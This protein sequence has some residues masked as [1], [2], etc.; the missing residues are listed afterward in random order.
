MYI[1]REAEIASLKRDIAAERKEIEGM[2]AAIAK[3]DAEI[4]ETKAKIAA[5]RKEIERLE[6]EKAKAMG[7]PEVEPKAQQSA[8]LDEANERRSFEETS[9]LE[10]VPGLAED[11]KDGMATPLEDC[12]GQQ[13]LEW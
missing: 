3:A 9:Y 2:K 10:R 8:V 1:T 13:D 4:A 6:A 7:A 11:I 12:V 5:I